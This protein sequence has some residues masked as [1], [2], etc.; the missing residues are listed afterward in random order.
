[1]AS[2]NFT[3]KHDIPA[4]LTFSLYENGEPIVKDIAVMAFSLTMD[5]KPEGTYSYYV[6]SV[7]AV[8]KLESVPSAAISVNFIKPAAPHG[9][10]ALLGG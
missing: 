2:L 3:W 9:L 5:G 10:T 1:M 6:T 4:N 8:T 7:D